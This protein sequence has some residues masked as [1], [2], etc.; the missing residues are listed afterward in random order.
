MKAV[1]N[2]SARR[3]LV[4][5]ESMTKLYKPNTSQFEEHNSYKVKPNKLITVN[6]KLS[7]CPQ[8]CIV[9]IF[10]YLNNLS[11]LD[12]ING[13][14][15]I[16]IGICSMW[17]DERLVGYQ[18]DETLPDNL[19]GPSLNLWNSRGG[20]NIEYKEFYL[21]NSETG[22]LT[23]TARYITTCSFEVSKSFFC[24]PF[25]YIDV[26]M[27]MTNASTGVLNNGEKVLDANYATNRAFTIV[28][29]TSRDGL[30]QFWTFRG[31]LTE[32]K[33]LGCSLDCESNNN[34]EV[35]Q[36]VCL[37]FHY[38]RRN[39]YY[40]YKVLLPTLMMGLVSCWVFF[41]DVLDLTSRLNFLLTAILSTFALLFVIGADI[42][43]AEKLMCLDKIILMSL[44]T[45]FAAGIACIY[46]DY[47][48]ICIA[49]CE[50]DEC[51]DCNSTNLTA[52]V[53]IVGSF[54]LL[55]LYFV[56]T[57][58]Y[59]SHQFKQNTMKKINFKTLNE[60]IKD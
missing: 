47:S 41:I 32:W 21:V 18:A 8:N 36:E 50:G 13:T 1:S 26:P 35:T 29:S 6:E 49:D 22:L 44:V 28:P 34:E 15:D 30:F 16:D 7:E 58:I 52:G 46:I 42:P 54:V 39:S 51:V 25:D 19:W 4:S 2:R 20:S 60:C 5:D 9:E 48:K 55:S 24:F 23:R 38:A 45:N 10:F 14:A 3:K 17:H 37:F 57:P 43:R 31:D 40:I 12:S 53:T 59:F 11:G 27:R 56:I 33:M